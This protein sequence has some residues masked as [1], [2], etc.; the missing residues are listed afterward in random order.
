LENDNALAWV[1]SL[2]LLAGF[3]TWGLCG[4]PPIPSRWWRGSG[5]WSLTTLWRAYRAAFWGEYHFHPLPFV[6]PGNWPEK[7]TL[8]SSLAQS[9]FS[10]A[11]P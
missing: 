8:L 5:R 4:P 3:R 1:Y 2:L 10:A 11:R 9:A 7:E 6:F